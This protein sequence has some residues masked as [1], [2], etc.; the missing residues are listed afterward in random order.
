MGRYKKGE[1]HLRFAKPKIIDIHSKSRQI[2]AHSKLL[3]ERSLNYVVNRHV[4]VNSEKLKDHKYLRDLKSTTRRDKNACNI[5]KCGKYIFET[6]EKQTSFM[7]ENIWCW[8]LFHG[9]EY[10]R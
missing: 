9:E 8:L 10:I 4:K 6:T 5:H 2:S 1:G 7:R 3:S